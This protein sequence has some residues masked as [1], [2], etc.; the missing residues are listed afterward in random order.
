MTEKTFKI[1]DG[2]ISDGYH[3]FDELYEHRNLL[4]INL[5]KRVGGNQSCYWVAEHYPGWDLLVIDSKE[6]QMSYHVP[7]QL[8]PCYEKRDR[9][10]LS[11]HGYDGHTPADVVER[12][13]A[14]AMRL[15]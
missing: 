14:M 11:Q 5:F 2:D 3:T 8:R 6:G 1:K 7:I 12:L 15:P 10:E 9:L 13:R 4:F